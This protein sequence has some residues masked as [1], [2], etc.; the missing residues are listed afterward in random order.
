PCSPRPS[1]AEARP[2][3]GRETPEADRAPSASE[4]TEALRLHPQRDVEHRTD[5]LHRHHRRQL[6]ESRLGV[7]LRGAR[8]ALIAHPSARGRHRLRELEGHPLGLGVYYAHRPGHL[9]DVFGRRPC[10]AGRARAW[11]PSTI[12]ALPTRPFYRGEVRES[13]NP[14]YAPKGV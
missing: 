9:T 7:M 11:A 3:G 1:R 2:P 4:R 8:E 13:A 12:D 6:H 14:D 10:R 5:V